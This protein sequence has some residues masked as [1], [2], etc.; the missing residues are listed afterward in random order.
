MSDI[1]KQVYDNRIFLENLIRKTQRSLEKAPDGSLKIDTS[2]GRIKYYR[3][4]SGS[5]THPVYIPKKNMDLAAALAQKDYDEK[6]LRLL[7]KK[8][9]ILCKFTAQFPDAHI[10]SV[11]ESLSPV[12]QMLVQPAVPTTSQ[13]IKEWQ[14]KPY[15]GLGFRDDDTTAYY[16][17]KGERVRSKTEMII[18]NALCRACIP[19][20]YECPLQLGERVVY[21]DFTIL[22]IRAHT[23]TYFEHFGRMDDP[24]YAGKTMQKI[25]LYARHGIVQGKNLLYTM[26]TSEQPL[27][28]RCLDA[29][30]RENLAGC[31]VN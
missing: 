10:D 26:E 4:P 15:K 25:N 3:R 19:Y 1:S 14:E 6:V 22:D 7:K 16:T 21:P 20:K 30:I 12:R 13:F 29:I 11:Y 31:A 27:D 5:N 8:L 18:A 23:E 28:T 2:S 9:R 24:A 17:I